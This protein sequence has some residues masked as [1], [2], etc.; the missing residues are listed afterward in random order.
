MRQA[1]SHLGGHDPGQRRLA[2]SGRPGEQEV[3]GR[4][5][6]T[7]GRFQHDL[8]M[9][10]QLRLTD[11]FRQAVW[12]QARLVGELGRRGR[13]IDW[14]GL[15]FVL[16]GGDDLAPGAHRLPASS[17]SASRNISSTGP[18]VPMPFS[19]WRISSVP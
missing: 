6:P 3:V 18:S 17:R 2:E 12:T 15:V 19:A 5:L 16:L 4:L 11:E 14:S 7:A 9:L 1:G 8:E 10:G 13:R